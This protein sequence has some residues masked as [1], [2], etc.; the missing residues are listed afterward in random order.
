M[1]ISQGEFRINTGEFVMKIVKCLLFIGAIGL[2]S[3]CGGGGG[4]DP[5]APRYAG[6]WSGWVGLISNS[7]PR[8]I[9]EEFQS[10]SLLHNVDQGVSKGDQGNTLVDIVLDDGIDTYVGVGEVDAQGE[11]NAFSATGSAHELPGFLNSYVC[12]E[13]IDFTYESIDFANNTAGFVTRHSSIVC[14]RGNNVRTC[15]VTYTGNSYRTAV[16]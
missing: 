13:T 6:A 9:P 8:A 5:K 4:G 3:S 11:G 10:I 2:L 1:L 16:G 14:T 12:I 15:D 7:C